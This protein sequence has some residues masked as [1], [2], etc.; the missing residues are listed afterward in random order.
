MQRAAAPVRGHLATAA[1]RICGGPNGLQE[2]FFRGHAER[3]A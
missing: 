3:Q 1:G 2:H